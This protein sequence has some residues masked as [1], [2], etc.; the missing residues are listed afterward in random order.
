VR[1]AD[2]RL[3]EEYFLLA[4]DDYTGRAHIDADVL[5]AGLAGALLAGLVI[6]GCLDARGGYVRALDGTGPPDGVTADAVAAIAARAHPVPWW[7]ECLAPSVYSRTGE[8]LVRE[9]VLTRAPAGLFRGG[10]RYPAVDALVAAGP[11]VRLRHEADAARPVPPAPAVATLAALALRTGLHKV[12]ADAANR[13]A[14]DGLAA[15]ARAVPATVRP[16]VDGVDAALI[17]MALTT[18]RGR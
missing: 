3:H 1:H 16:V 4:H 5:A 15:L 7:V 2:A 13:S 10:I 14:R 8:D 12:I 18:P 11:R 6:A 17:R 9:G